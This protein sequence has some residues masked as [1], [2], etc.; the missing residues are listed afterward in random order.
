MWFFVIWGYLY[1]NGNITHSAISFRCVDFRNGVYLT[2]CMKKYY[3]LYVVA[4]VAWLAS[5][6]HTFIALRVTSLCHIWTA[7]KV[8]S[9]S[10]IQLWLSLCTSS[11]IFIW[12]DSTTRPST[13][14][15]N[16]FVKYVRPTA[17]L[18]QCKIKER[19][20]G[21]NEWNVDK[22]RKTTG[23]NGK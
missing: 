14:H 22:K 20:D 5:L 1:R 7:V 8:Y 2:K 10:G 19:R 23:R 11:L 6:Q 9:P 15:M 16:V 4:T 13:Y 18:K 21:G 17:N 3:F 12:N